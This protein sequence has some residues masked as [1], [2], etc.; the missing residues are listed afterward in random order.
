[1]ALEKYQEMGDDVHAELIRTKISSSD[2]K[3]QE[4]ET[5]KQQAEAYMEAAKAR[6]AEGNRL[7]AKK[8]YLFAKNI[9]REL[10]MDE[11][12]AEIDGLLEIL[13]TGMEQEEA[14][15]IPVE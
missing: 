13:E 2:Q 4:A 6:E 12:V 8:Q 1:M 7:E 11:K 3:G 14:A 5:K 15:V 10:K 9:Y